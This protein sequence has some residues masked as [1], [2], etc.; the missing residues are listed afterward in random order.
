LKIQINSSY[1]AQNYKD[2][3][4]Q[5][6]LSWT[7]SEPK[8]NEVQINCPNTLPVNGIQEHLGLPVLQKTF[9]KT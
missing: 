8:E 2:A 7:K 4:M 3:Q 6:G 1:Y 9:I 5:C